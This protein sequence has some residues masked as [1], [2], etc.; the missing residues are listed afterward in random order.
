MFGIYPEYGRVIPTKP[1]VCKCRKLCI[2]FGWREHSQ[3]TWVKTMVSGVDFPFKSIETWM[4]WQVLLGANSCGPHRRFGAPSFLGRTSSVS[5]SARGELWR[6]EVGRRQTVWGCRERCW[7]GTW[8]VFFLTGPTMA[9][10]YSDFDSGGTS[11][12]QELGL[13]PSTSR[14]V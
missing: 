12:S 9:L 14:L 3:A 11:N 2:R 10:G 8:G 6:C 1:E 13:A 7:V 5:Q 4:I